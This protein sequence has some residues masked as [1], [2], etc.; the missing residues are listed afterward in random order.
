MIDE[1]DERSMR[2]FRYL[3]NV[4][5]GVLVSSLSN[6]NLKLPSIERFILS[7]IVNG[8]VDFVGGEGGKVNYQDQDVLREHSPFLRLAWK[9]LVDEVG[10]SRDKLDPKVKGAL[11][12]L[13]RPFDA[14][15]SNNLLYNIF[16]DFTGTGRASIFSPD[17]DQYFRIKKKVI[18]SFSDSERWSV[19]GVG[20]AM[21]NYIEE[22]LEYIKRI[23]KW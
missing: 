6:D 7:E 23:Y 10:K 5:E 12:K 22:D 16:P 9:Y 20:R 1:K 8:T 4:L 19:G 17:L 14:N 3:E 15:P 18:P 21:R 11:F 13:V 2:K